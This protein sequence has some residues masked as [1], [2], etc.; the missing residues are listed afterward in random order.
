[1]KHLL[2]KTV[3]IL[4]FI[5]GANTI[6]AD[7]D[8]EAIEAEGM[9]WASLYQN[10]DLDGLMSLYVSDAIV[11]LHAQPALFGRDAIRE[12]FAPSIGKAEST[13]ELSYE[14][15]ESHGDIAYII[16]K[17]WLVAKDK[18]TGDKYRDAGRSL[19][20][21]KK[22]EGSWKIAAD[23]DQSTPDVTWPS[24]NGLK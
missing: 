15:I 6:I 16:S 19:L 13:F 11:A 7:N 12:Y 1:M 9:K 18:T 14:L 8:K 2:T 24:P 20:V 4:F 10:G 3:F 23:I 17:Y 21:Y 22:E 5:I